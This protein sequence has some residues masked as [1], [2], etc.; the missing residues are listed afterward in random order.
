MTYFVQREQIKKYLDLEIEDNDLFP[1][2]A[3]SGTSFYE[4][5]PENGI[6]YVVTIK[7]IITLLKKFIH[8]EIDNNRVRGYVE[9]L[10]ALDLFEFDESDD[11]GHDAIVNAIFTVDEIEDVNGEITLDEAK[12]ILKKITE[13]SERIEGR[14]VKSTQ[15]SANPK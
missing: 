8:G 13:V 14:T 12:T 3:P 9:S 6:P 11:E 1:E 10:I 15:S 7:H 5:E 4:L 2:A